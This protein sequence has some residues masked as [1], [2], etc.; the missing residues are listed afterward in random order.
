MKLHYL[1]TADQL[2]SLV[3]SDSRRRIELHIKPVDEELWVLVA[4][5][6]DPEMQPERA[7]CQGPYHDARQAEGALRGIAA[8]LIE[9]G[10]DV[11]AK[12]HPVWTICAQRH[13]REVREGRELHSGQYSF[14]PDQLEPL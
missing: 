1:H 10:Y 12:S 8:A 2:R 13:A 6:G 14:D 5:A 3:L 7:K 11:V 9:Q 4:L